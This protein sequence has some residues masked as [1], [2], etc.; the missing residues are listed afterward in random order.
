MNKAV[1]LGTLQYRHRLVIGDVMS[2]AGLTA[3]IGHVSDTDT[4][5][6]EIVG[7]ALVDLLTAYT[8]GADRSTDMSFI[9]L[10]PVGNMLNIYCA[11]LHGDRLLDR[12]NMHSYSGASGRYQL[13]DPRKG[14]ISHSLKEHRQLGMPVEILKIHIRILGG[15]GNEKRYPVFAV[16]G[17]TACAGVYLSP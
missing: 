6:V 2:A 8:A 16:L 9:T 12:N 13:C 14:K 10:Q 7:T 5:V 3:V 1:V 15:T 17:L 4:P 11:V